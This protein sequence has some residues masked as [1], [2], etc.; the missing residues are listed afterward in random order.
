MKT[1]LHKSDKHM[2]ENQ[3][4]FDKIAGAQDVFILFS[5]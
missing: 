3:Q 2:N 1:I 5:K 4:N